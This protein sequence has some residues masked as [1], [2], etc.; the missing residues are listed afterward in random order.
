MDI[1][2]IAFLSIFIVIFIA[3]IITHLKVVPEY[4]RLVVFRLG[5]LLSVKGPGIVFLVPIIDR[6]VEVDLR[7]FVLDIPPQT[8]ITKDNA[9]VDVDLL[10]YMKIFDAIKAVTEVQ[11]YVTASTGIAI[12][13]LR[14]IIG[15]M[16]LDDVLA[17]RE[18]I[19]ST[20]RA[21]LD[22][23]TDRWGIK[24]T[25]VEIKEIKPPREVQEA[26]I[27]QMAAERNRRAMILEAEGK[28]TAAILEAEGQREAM[29]KKGEGEKQYEILVAEGKAKALEMI[30]EVAMRLGSNALLL[31][32]MEALKTIAQSPATK[33]VIPLEMLSAMTRIFSIREERH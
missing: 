17:K 27:K 7:E 18:Y 10:I 8:C 19:N 28:K 29:I 9:P 2:S 14:A 31:Q 5:R 4:K 20:L 12:T 15:D 25:S 24:V 22:E 1:V 26:M 16:Q 23:V 13:T 33:I 21:K 32:Y 30:N 6:G 11:N 3:I